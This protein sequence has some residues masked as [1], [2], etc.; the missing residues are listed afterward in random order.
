M[1]SHENL[2]LSIIRN[3]R[4]LNLNCKLIFRL[5]NIIFNSLIIRN[6]SLNLIGIANIRLELIYSTILFFSRESLRRNVPKLNNIH[7]IYHYINLLWLIIPAGFI[8]ISFI[9]L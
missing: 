6:I 9:L 1:S 7:S 3:E 8:L 4:I 5:I 2:F